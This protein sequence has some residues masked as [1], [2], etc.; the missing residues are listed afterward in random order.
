MIHGN[1]TITKLDELLSF[2]VSCAKTRIFENLALEEEI[3]QLLKTHPGLVWDPETRQILIHAE[4]SGRAF[5]IG[6]RQGYPSLGWQAF[7]F[8]GIEPCQGDSEIELWQDKIIQ[9][10]VNS[11]K[12]LVSLL[13]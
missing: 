8:D 6:I 13:D 7:E 1:L 11:L 9:A 4:T 3:S 12:D 2:I 5:V 10:Q